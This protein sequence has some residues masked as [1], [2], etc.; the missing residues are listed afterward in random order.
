MSPLTE[1]LAAI[2]DEWDHV[3][4]VLSDLQ[5]QC[6]AKDGTIIGLQQTLVQQQQQLSRQ[7]A[8]LTSLK[9]QLA[10]MQQQVTA[11]LLTAHDPDDAKLK[12]RIDAAYNAM[13]SQKPLPIA[14]AA[15]AHQAPGPSPVFPGPAPTRPAT[16]LSNA[17]HSGAGSGSERMA[18]SVTPIRIAPT[19]SNGSRAGTNGQP[20]KINGNGQI[21]P[22]PQP[23]AAAS[24]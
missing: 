14:N 10:A 3:S 22:Q 1:K 16:P 13:A 7:S 19:S 15:P 18:V 12:Q 17:E 2:L 6:T 4:G 11:S 9:N 24:R 5:Q 21:K 20:A 23:I 8:E